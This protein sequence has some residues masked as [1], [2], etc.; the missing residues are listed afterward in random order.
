MTKCAPL[1]VVQLLVKICPKACNSKDKD[2]N[3]PIDIAM[4]MKLP[5]G[6]N[7]N[8]DVV[9]FLLKHNPDAALAKIDKV[10]KSN[11]LRREGKG[12]GGKRGGRKNRR[13]LDSLTALEKTGLSPLPDLASPSKLPEDLIPDTS[14][15]TKLSSPVLPS[16]SPLS[17]RSE[18]LMLKQDEEDGL[19]STVVKKK[20]KMKRRAR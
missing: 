15:L 19:T 4:A 17:P 1:D 6:V 5:S 16:L 12:G 7:R 20:P 18:A 13:S 8:P 14:T 11:A 9:G 2:K 10:M 3:R